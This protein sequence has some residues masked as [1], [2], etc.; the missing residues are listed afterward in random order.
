VEQKI[1]RENMAKFEKIEV[2]YSSILRETE[3]AIQVGNFD[4]TPCAVWLPKSQLTES[5][6]N[7]TLLIPEWLYNQKMEE[8]G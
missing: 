4:G 8:L 6:F 5:E 7:D 1:G 3:K 2:Q